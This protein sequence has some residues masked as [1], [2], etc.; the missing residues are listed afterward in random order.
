MYEAARFRSGL[1]NVQA[2]ILKPDGSLAGPF[3]LR[4]LPSVFA[5]RYFF[6]FFTGPTD[7]EG[8]Y[9]ASIFSPTENIQTTVRISLYQKVVTK[10]S[11]DSAVTAIND[12]LEELIDQVNFIEANVV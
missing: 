1:T 5:G 4:E 3:L 2:F 6:D 9:F 12:S 11:F 10:A 7:S 8:E